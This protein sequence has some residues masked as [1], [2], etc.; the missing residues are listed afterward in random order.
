MLFVLTI[1]LL[2]L[3]TIDVLQV[4]DVIDVSLSIQGCNA[5]LGM[6]ATITSQYQGA[7]GAPGAGD[8]RALVF[9][10]QSHLSTIRTLS[11]QLLL[12]VKKLSP[13]TIAL[14]VAVQPFPNCRLSPAE[15]GKEETWTLTALSN[16]GSVTPVADGNKDLKAYED[17]E[18]VSAG[19]QN[20]FKL[21]G[22]FDINDDVPGKICCVLTPSVVH[23]PAL[24]KWYSCSS[25][26]DAST[27]PRFLSHPRSN[28]H[29][30]FHY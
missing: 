20:Q 17:V 13:T 9:S 19:N 25:K 26:P 4:S 30:F 5:D 11:D 22:Q 24:L 3:V 18:M 10:G 21:S 1:V 2:P 12:K 23:C 14:A 28:L 7:T 6:K 29:W 15:V 8:T 27:L 16:I